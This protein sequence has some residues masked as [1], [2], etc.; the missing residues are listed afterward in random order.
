MPMLSTLIVGASV[1]VIGDSH[2]SKP[3]YLIKSLHDE[4]SR[5]GAL[6][7]SL[8]ACGASAADWLASTKMVCGAERIGNGPVT[9]VVQNASTRP[10][11]PLIAADKAKL[12]VIVMGDTMANYKKD[13]AKAWAWQQVTSLSKEIASSGAACVW[14]GP[15]WGEGGQ[16]GKTE[17]RVKMMSDFL[18]ANV[19]PC[20]YIDSLKLSQPKTWPTVDGQHLFPGGYQA[21]GVALGKAIAELPLPA[22]P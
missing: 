8:S 16:Y 13:F 20:Q 11:K 1:L 14:V 12:V 3:D 21:W 7:H 19:A 22:R 4:L 2:L 9:L 17:A 6:V 15:P 5:Q 18:A 10:V